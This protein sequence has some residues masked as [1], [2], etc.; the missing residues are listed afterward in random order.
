MAQ[1]SETPIRVLC[2]FSELDIGGAESMCMSLY[3]QLDKSRVQ[4]D[5]VKHTPKKCDFEEE[6]ISLGGHIFEAPR[7]RGSNHSAYTKWWEAHLLAHPEH[8]IIHG[9]YYTIAAIYFKVA[10][11]LGRITI[12]HSHST[13]AGKWKLRNLAATFW[14]SKINRYSD[15]RLACSIPA[16][17][18]LYGD[19]PFTVFHNAIDS[20]KFV[21]D[22]S[23]REA[24]RA[25]FGVSEDF[26]VGTVASLY[27]PKNPLGMVEIVRELKKRNPATKCLWVGIGSMYEAV[28]S[29][30]HTDGL[31]DCCMLLGE[32]T[33][34]NRILQALDAFLLPSIYE[35]L[36]VVAVEAQA[37]G[38]PCFI[39]DVVTRE[40]DITGL[41]SFLPVGDPAL[42]A[43]RLLAELPPRRDTRRD[44]IDSGYDVHNT[45]AWLEQFYSDLAGK[46]N[47]AAGR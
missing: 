10:K 24:V 18:W 29:Q 4:F 31:E 3:R 5:F 45:A 6:I 43:D 46:A 13:S 35:G 36:P 9:H 17:K 39:S 8:Q 44:L 19:A 1:K 27:Y 38:L 25:E 42:W 14:L 20:G 12:A 41:C 40:V 11:R 7:Y 28:K 26:V 15:Y 34:V 22:P 30:I 37:A 33:D 47:K 2:V 23:V 16:G 21:Y 32:R